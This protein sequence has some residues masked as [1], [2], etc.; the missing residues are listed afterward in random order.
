MTFLKRCINTCVAFGV[1]FKM[2][3]K[4]LGTERIGTHPVECIFEKMRICSHFNHSEK[5]AL[6][7]LFGALLLKELIDRLP[8]TFTIKKRDN[9]GGV[10]LPI[11]IAIG[12]PLNIIPCVITNSVFTLLIQYPM[13]EQCLKYFRS[14]IDSYSKRIE[15]DPRSQ[16][17]ISLVYC[18]DLDQPVEM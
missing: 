2:D 17:Y 5:N 6:S 3:I 12:D 14:M 16:K 10:H 9:A 18:L 7:V 8:V 11:K 4:N 13:N 1:A 15:L